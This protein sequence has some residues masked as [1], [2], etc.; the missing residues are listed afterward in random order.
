[1]LVLFTA[2]LKWMI[3]PSKNFSVSVLRCGVYLSSLTSYLIGHQKI[4]MYF[5]LYTNAFPIQRISVKETRN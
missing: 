3:K 1:M 5:S 4:F 2:I